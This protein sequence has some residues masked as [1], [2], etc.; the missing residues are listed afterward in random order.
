MTEQRRERDRIDH[1]AVP[2]LVGA[3]DAKNAIAFSRWTTLRAAR[4]PLTRIFRPSRMS[5]PT[6]AQTACTASRVG[7]GAVPSSTVV[8]AV[9]S[10]FA[11]ASNLLALLALKKARV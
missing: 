8:A 2:S 1:R 6:N 11:M 3:S 10:S 9:A 4:G 7:S 5:H